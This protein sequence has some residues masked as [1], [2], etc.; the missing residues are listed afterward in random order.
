MKAEAVAK[1]NPRQITNLLKCPAK[2]K[3]KFAKK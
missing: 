2:V 1:L 3:A